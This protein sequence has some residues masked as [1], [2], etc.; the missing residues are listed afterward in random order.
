MKSFILAVSLVLVST[1]LSGCGS[2]SEE[3]RVYKVAYPE[4]AE[5]RAQAE[6]P[7]EA[8]PTASAPMAPL[9]GMVEAT[10]AVGNPEWTVP[11]DWE[12]LPPTSMRKGNFRVTEGAAS[13]E[14][15]VTVFPGDVGGLE[16]NVNRWRRQVGMGPVGP[17]GIAEVTRTIKV[18]GEEA[19][20][21]D[22]IR[23]EAPNAPAILGVVIPRGDRTWFV[24]ASGPSSVL[25]VQRD[26]IEAFADSFSF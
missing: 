18:D 20:V 23:A 8:M 1:L 9:P 25:E 5:Q 6:A 22:L 15:S 16:A 21:V 4:G 12:E 7:E 17:D 14:I 19:T 3:V 13:A 2:E 24:K 11:E 10:A 26:N